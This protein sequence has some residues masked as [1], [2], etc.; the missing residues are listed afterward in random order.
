MESATPH[1]HHTDTP[2]PGTPNTDLA[3]HPKIIQIYLVDTSGGSRMASW[4]G[5]GAQSAVC[6]LSKSGFGYKLHPR[7]RALRD[8]ACATK[9]KPK[10]LKDANRHHH[11]PSCGQQ[12]AHGGCG[13]IPDGLDK[14]LAVKGRN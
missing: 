11:S 10:N 13:G 9:R 12:V 1:S 7:T 5:G 3:P 4:K 14:A 2:N 8:I 6:C